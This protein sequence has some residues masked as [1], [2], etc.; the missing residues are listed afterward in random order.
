MIE[1]GGFNQKTTYYVGKNPVKK[2]SIANCVGLEVSEMTEGIW[3][4]PVVHSSLVIHSMP[5]SLIAKAS[6]W[7]VLCATYTSLTNPSKVSSGLK[8]KSRKSRGAPIV[9][10][11]WAPEWGTWKVDKG[12]NRS[13]AKQNTPSLNTPLLTTQREELLH[14]GHSDETSLKSD[15]LSAFKYGEVSYSE[16]KQVALWLLPPQID[17]NLGRH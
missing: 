17:S 8:A 1:W 15:W 10:W 9:A 2:W 11:F 14:M 5:C 6:S 3:S 7:M 16:Q 13:F 12:V 4:F